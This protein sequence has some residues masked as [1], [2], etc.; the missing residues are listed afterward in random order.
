[1]L[2]SVLRSSELKEAA[3]RRIGKSLKDK[4][5]LDE[6]IGLGGTAAVYAATHRNGSRVA[7]KVLHRH[8]SGFGNQVRRFLQEAY[9]ANLVGHSGAV[10]VHDDDIEGEDAFLV[11]EL[12]DGVNLKD[13]AEAKGGRLP[14]DE[15]LKLAD[16][17]L[18]VLKEAHARGIVHRDIK[19]SNLFLSRSGG[20]KVLD[21]G[22]ARALIPPADA[23]TTAEGDVIG[24]PAFMAPEQARGKNQEVD[25][26]ADVWSVGATLFTLLSGELVHPASTATEHLYLTMS[27]S[28]RSFSSVCPDLP[29]SLVD[30][31]DR[32]LEHDPQRRWPT[33]AALQQA[34]RVLDL[35]SG[36]KRRSDRSDAEL[37]ALATA[38]LPVLDPAAP[39]SRWSKARGALAGVAA[40]VAVIS[41]FLA[42]AL[43]RD[44]TPF[45]PLKAL[46]LTSH[47][48]RPAPIAARTDDQRATRT[49]PAP[50]AAVPSLAPASAPSRQIPAAKK[51][52]R[53]PVTVKAAK[54][55]V[56]DLPQPQSTNPLDWR[57]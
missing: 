11:M 20:L 24:T 38:T 29:S 26:R 48:A 55:K 18:D 46:D 10:A 36:P 19:P 54:A 39:P 32:C 50:Q 25:A 23:Q 28:A 7:I 47:Q 41:L 52:R 56:P 33:A 12:L 1:M 53:P 45:R 15:T 49:T 4:W 31:I 27:A 44:E 34:L 21:F 2:R 5:R 42:S 35:T 3:E 22:V 13:H 8:L 16:E 51:P 14:V 57:H 40:V 17:L 9:A 37:E 30:L 43:T 6:L